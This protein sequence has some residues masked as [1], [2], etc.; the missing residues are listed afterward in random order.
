MTFEAKQISLEMRVLDNLVEYFM[1]WNTFFHPVKFETYFT[2]ISQNMPQFRGVLG[3]INPCKDG[4]SHD[5]LSEEDKKEVETG[6]SME[7]L[8]NLYNNVRSHLIKKMPIF[9][10]IGKSVSSVTIPLPGEPLSGE[11]KENYPTCSDWQNK[12]LFSDRK[13]TTLVMSR[14][15]DFSE[16]LRNTKF[17]HTVKNEDG[18]TWAQFLDAIMRMKIVKCSE[19]E[20]FLYFQEDELKID[21]GVL[22]LTAVFHM[23]HYVCEI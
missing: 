14:K 22:K 19:G 23:E 21:D 13:I 10:I 20:S 18:I 3:K 5:Y 12:P 1:G 4:W 2:P 16:S 8:G 6:Y 17:E 9:D 11:K 7:L 15:N